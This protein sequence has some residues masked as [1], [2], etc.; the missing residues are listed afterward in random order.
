MHNA[1]TLS[2]PEKS[3]LPPARSISTSRAHI[4]QTII[5]KCSWHRLAPKFTFQVE[6]RGRSG[7]RLLMSLSAELEPCDY[8][9]AKVQINPVWVMT[10]LIWTKCAALC[11]LCWKTHHTDVWMWAT[12][13]VF[14]WVFFSTMVV[15]LNFCWQNIPIVPTWLLTSRALSSQSLSTQHH[16]SGRHRAGFKTNIQILTWA[17]LSC[18]PSKCV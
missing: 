17:N 15:H 4:I 9:G 1:D 12:V 16:L 6:A 3:I 5:R 2:S 14:C 13:D 10:S 8:F 11:S 7:S 18:A